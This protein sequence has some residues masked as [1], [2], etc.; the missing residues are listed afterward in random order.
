MLLYMEKKFIAE[1]IIL[2]YLGGPKSNHKG[3]YENGAEED[4]IYT[5]EEEAMGPWRKRLKRCDHKT[6]SVDSHQE[7]GKARNRFCLRAFGRKVALLMPDFSS[8]KRILDFWPLE[9]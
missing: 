7:L 9:L 2:V 3:P 8:V 4:F 1:G 6:R 5:E